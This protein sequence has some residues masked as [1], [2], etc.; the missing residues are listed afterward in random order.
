MIQ[1]HRQPLAASSRGRILQVRLGINPNSSGFGIHYAF[2][3]FLP[4]AILSLLVALVVEP[5]LRRA[6]RS[7]QP[8]SDRDTTARGAVAALVWALAWALPWVGVFV[9]WEPARVLAL[10][11]SDP[12][13][14]TGS[15]F[16]ILLLVLCV[17]ITLAITYLVWRCRRHPLLAK[18]SAAAAGSALILMLSATMGWMLLYHSSIQEF[19]STLWF[20]PVASMALALIW[21][22]LR[23][24]G[25]IRS[26]AIGL[27]YLVGGI[28]TLIVTFLYIP[29]PIVGGINGVSL[30]FLLWAVGFPL[31]AAIYGL[32]RLRRTIDANPES[33]V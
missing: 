17:L 6:L 2:F 9:F 7:Q 1:H 31:L 20:L 16:T 28:V 25:S 32:L 30:Y 19:F 22:A 4:P 29:S 26:L 23:L 18:S 8:A 27:V 21:M 10:S 14:I 13:G 12:V 33:T 3:F 5:W 15:Y 11:T 24:S